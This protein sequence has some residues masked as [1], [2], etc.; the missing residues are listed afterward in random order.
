MSGDW[1]IRQGGRDDLPG[2]EA[3]WRALY[4]HHRAVATAAL[5]FVSADERWPERLREFEQSFDDH[6]AALLIA[7]SGGAPVGFAFSTMRPP[8]PI[9]MSGRIGELEVLVVAPERRGEGIGEE[10]LERSRELLREMGAATLMLDVLAGN[11]AALRFYRRHGIEP[12]RIEF[13]APL[14][15][16]GES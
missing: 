7:S 9:F 2:L 1:E 16:P 11:D 3:L 13:F 14:R 8:S 4:A 15:G 6:A 12:A 5:P 10:L